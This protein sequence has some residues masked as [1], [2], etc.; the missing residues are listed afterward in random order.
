[1]DDGSPGVFSSD[2]HLDITSQS[3][4]ANLS[5]S[6][7][8]LG[9]VHIQAPDSG[10]QQQQTQR[11]Q[12]PGGSSSAAACSSSSF[13]RISVPSPIPPQDYSSPS[14]SSSAAGLA[15]GAGP[16]IGGATSQPAMV[17]IEDSL[18]SF[19]SHD[20]SSESNE[21][22]SLMTTSSNKPSESQR[23]LAASSCNT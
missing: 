2:S 15:A 16:A 5:M 8:S 17:Q 11:R 18:E 9:I 13:L 21:L 19:R 10:G 12:E 23:D 7:P 14:S 6:V 1:M 22:Q 3:L 20:S 4:P